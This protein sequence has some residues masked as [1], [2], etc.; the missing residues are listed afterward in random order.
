MTVDFAMHGV[1]SDHVLP[2]PV[3]ENLM[4]NGEIHELTICPPESITKSAGGPLPR[5]MISRKSAMNY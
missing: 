1:V 5:R 4:P 2:F 3:H